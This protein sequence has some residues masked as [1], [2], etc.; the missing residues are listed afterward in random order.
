MRPA[1]VALVLLLACTSSEPP[2]PPAIDSPRL[3][4]ASDPSC[5]GA[6]SIYAEGAA[7]LADGDADRAQGNWIVFMR[8]ED[9]DPGLARCLEKDYALVGLADLA[10]A[11]GDIESAKFIYRQVAKTPDVK[12]RRYV[13]DRLRS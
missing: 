8:G 1:L 5:S 4:R 2:E 11:E 13:R 6:F 9:R 12:L 3:S 10:L 7:A